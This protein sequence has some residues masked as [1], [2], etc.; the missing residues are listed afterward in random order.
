MNVNTKPNAAA[1][2]TSDKETAID[3]TKIDTPLERVGKKIILPGDPAEMPY[4]IALE[5][6]ERIRD[7]ELQ[8]YDVTETVK[9][10]PWD[11]LV[12]LYRSMQDIYGVVLPKTMHLW[13]GDRNPAFESIKTGPH[14]RDI[15][16]V[17]VGQMLL[18]GMAAPVIVAMYG[19]GAYIKGEVNKKD[20]A[21]LVEVSVKARKYLRT[22]S[23]Y[24]AKAI[25][26]KVDDDGDL[27][28]NQQP[29]F[30]DLS[31][32]NESDMIHNP[33][34]ERIIET[35]ILAPLKHSAAC[36]KHKIPLK[37]GI[38]LEGKYGCGKSLTARVTA[39]VAVEN[40]W[41]FIDLQRPDGLVS[42][43]TAATQLQPAV[44]FSEDLD[45]FADRSSS[46][47]NEMINI[48]DGMVPATAEI[49]T[50]L[51]TNFVENIDKALLRPGRLDAVISIDAPDAATVGRLVRHYGGNN[52]PSNVPTHQVGVIL[53]GQIPA[54][55]A[56]V[57]KRSKLS[58]VTYDREQLTEDDLVVAA[59]SMTRHLALLAERDPEPTSGEKLAR[60]LAD[61]L[62]VERFN[63]RGDDA[64]ELLEKILE[65]VS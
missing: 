64:E 42:A 12:A 13:F 60:N 15:I 27:I 17:P 25:K 9:G 44:I 49:M 6:I 21:R 48:M 19:G 7:S 16:Q 11:A 1:P 46:Q 59:E 40:G 23:I 58:M 52:L 50:V 55:I 57:V 2:L 24:K 38:L 31:E 5:T 20:R 26:L 62:G 53:A 3:W 29:D 4:D 35:T 41:T 51:T 39:K 37:R 32:V 43:I 28:V 34:T 65:Q 61:I 33:I 22:E 14:D 54:T 47:V 36:R 30:L 56:E 8:T 45:R 63:K 18:P 10:L